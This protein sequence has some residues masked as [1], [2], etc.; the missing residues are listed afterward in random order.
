MSSGH[1]GW[2]ER[3]VDQ[4]QEAVAT[5]ARLHSAGAREGD[6]ADLLYQHWYVGLSAGSTPIDWTWQ[7][8]LAGALTQAHPEDTHWRRATVRAVDPHGGLVVHDPALPLG[9]HRVVGPP[10]IAHEP[11]NGQLPVVGEQVWVPGRLGGVLA[12]GWWRTWGPHWQLARSTGPGAE[13]LTRIYVAPRASNFVTAIT[14]MVRVLSEHSVP[15]LVKAATSHLMLTRPDRVVIYLPD[16]A[17]T[18]LLESLA[19]HLAGMLDPVGPP[20]SASHAPGLSW[21]HD[22]GGEQSFGQERCALI[23][24]ALRPDRDQASLLLGSQALDRISAAFL[25]A[26]LDPGRPHLRRK[27]QPVTAP[28]VSPGPTGHTSLAPEARLV[29]VDGATDAASQELAEVTHSVLDALRDLAIYDHD[30]ACWPAWE[31]ADLDGS[32]QMTGGVAHAYDGDAGILWA[33]DHLV[34]VT[35]RTDLEDLRQRARRQLARTGPALDGA[36]LFDG[37][38]GIALAMGEPVLGYLQRQVG[39]GEGTE[40]DHIGGLSGLILGALSTG[41]DGTDVTPAVLAILH[42]L[43]PDLVGS[44]THLVGTGSVTQR[45]LCGLGHGQSGIVLA[46]AHVLAADPPAA[47]VRPLHEALGQLLAWERA[48]YEPQRGWPDLRDSE[49]HGVSYPVWWCHGAAGMTMTRL[50]LLRLAEAGVDLGFGSVPGLDLRQV[51]AETEAG[52]MICGRSVM[53]HAAQAERELAH[54][55]RHGGPAPTT[56]PQGCGLTLCHGVGGAMDVLI[57]AADQWQVDEH[58]EN[59]RYAAAAIAD[60]LGED[61]RIW[62]TGWHTRGGAGLFMGLAGTAMVLARLAWPQSSPQARV[63]SPSLFGVPQA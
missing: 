9:G 38:A 5:A 48:W 47:L 53:F 46:L 60:W 32:T 12:Q 35:G 45:P 17:A 55:D 1:L 10:D 57:T 54:A 58:R 6:M 43:A 2:P 22:G 27:D 7:V 56:T 42:R 4:L 30:R 62:P 24:S 34:S 19:E 21:A 13:P 37:P 28:T 44:S 15:W 3:V 29:A 36:G 16:A 41:A 39:T 51:Q 8:P 40:V 61:P 52:V 23:A 50:E 14:A 59:A 49:S 33:L 31:L 26:G 25:V 11:P 18:S 63:P 20:L